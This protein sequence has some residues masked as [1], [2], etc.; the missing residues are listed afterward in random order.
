MIVEKTIPKAIIFHYYYQLN[1]CLSSQ[2]QH[3]ASIKFQNAKLVNNNWNSCTNIVSFNYRKYTKIIISRDY[4][5]L[6]K[7]VIV[8]SNY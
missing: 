6:N 5:W 7:K 1:L 8:T 3:K 4:D 2:N